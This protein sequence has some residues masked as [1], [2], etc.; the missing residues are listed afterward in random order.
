LE[1]ISCQF[2]KRLHKTLTGSI[3]FQL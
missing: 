1:I 2:D 3:P